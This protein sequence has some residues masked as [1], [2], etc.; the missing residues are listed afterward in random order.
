MHVTSPRIPSVALLLVVAG[1]GCTRAAPPHAPSLSALAGD[2]TLTEL[3]GQPAPTGAGG[4]RVSLHFDS[5]GTQVSGFAGCN[6]LSAIYSIG[7]GS[8]HFAVGAMTRMAC[9]EGIEL[10]RTFTDALSATTGY[11]VSGDELTLL[12]AS[13]PVARFSRGAP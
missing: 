4:R 3:N 10:E 5:N 2:W 13:G 1:V 12:G 11:R 9:I 8:I 6:R 7:D